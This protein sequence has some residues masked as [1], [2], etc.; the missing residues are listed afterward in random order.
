M[1][2]VGVGQQFT[3]DFHVCYMTMHACV[4]FGIHLSMYVT[5]SKERAHIPQCNAPENYFSVVGAA[6]GRVQEPTPG[7]TS[8]FGLSKTPCS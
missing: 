2:L 5:V 6:H 1:A 3:H 4:Y 7:S 8:L